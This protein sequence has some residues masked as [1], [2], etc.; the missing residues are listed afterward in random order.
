MAN[1]LG[2]CIASG[3]RYKLCQVA[4]LDDFGNRAE[5]E[6]WVIM[7]LGA[8]LCDPLLAV[9]SGLQRLEAILIKKKH[10]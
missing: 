3:P 6:E 4:G 9:F 2:K 7:E 5:S 10:K 1:G 8:G